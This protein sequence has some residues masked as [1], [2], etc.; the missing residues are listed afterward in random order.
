MFF[1]DQ[2]HQFFRPLTSKY[3][4]QIVECLRV[5]YLR[6]YS[7]LADYSQTLDRNQLVEL[8]QDAITRTPL[9]EDGDEGDT[10]MPVRSDREQAGWVLNTLLE[11][12][13][14]EKQM[15]EA[16]LSSTYA[17]TRLGRLF[18][19]PFVESNAGFRTRHRNTRNTRNALAAFVESPQEDLEVHDLLDAF[20]YSERIISDFTDVVAELD[21]RKRQLVQAVET[22]QLVE[23]ATDEFFDFMEKRFM[24]DLAVRLSADSVEKYRDEIHS[25]IERARR[26]RKEFK[27]KAEQ[28]LR[29]MAPGLLDEPGQSYYYFILDKIAARLHNACEVMLPALRRALHSFTRRAD[30]IIRQ[31]SF[32]SGGEQ[33]ELLEICR[34]LT[35][36]G[37]DAQQARLAAA[38][39]AAAV[40]NVG[41]IDPAQ[42]RLH[43]QRQRRVVNSQVEG[44]G[45]M[46]Q[47]DRKDLFI[48]QALG[49]A[50]SVNNRELLDYVRGSLNQGRSISSADLPVRD[51]KDL[52]RAAHIVET[53]SAG[54]SSEFS[55]RIRNEQRK[56]KGE[57][58]ESDV[59]TLELVE[60]DV[61]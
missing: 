15:D 61:S 24:P 58:F 52:L 34:E 41:F 26:K 6:V 30:I 47:G 28:E 12:G 21:E 5:L 39:D 13:W 42:V 1:Q 18:T 3:R 8:F 49:Q 11:Y 27:H 38:G 51:A 20:E 57:F 10:E 33:S 19:Q 44:E 53:A 48:R 54:T 46:S 23:R 14:V 36:A 50:F 37:E 32:M 22:E 2:Q 9:L 4:E 60:E 16:S 29:R 56:T 40:L 35:E 7:S 45:V 55:F 59:F 43:A 25:L 31:L 17:F